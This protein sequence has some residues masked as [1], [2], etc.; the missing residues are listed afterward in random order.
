[1]NISGLEPL[2]ENIAGCEI[3]LAD[4]VLR[5]IEVLHLHYINPVP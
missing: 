4:K 1:V 2:G 3:S 5:Q